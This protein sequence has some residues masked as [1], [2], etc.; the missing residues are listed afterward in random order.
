MDNIKAYAESPEK[1]QEFLDLL[2][3]VSGDAIEGANTEIDRTA[4]IT[5]REGF[6]NATLHYYVPKSSE[7]IMTTTGIYLSLIH[8]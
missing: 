3:T 1:M 2:D 6:Q 7:G 8:I 5:H 4:S